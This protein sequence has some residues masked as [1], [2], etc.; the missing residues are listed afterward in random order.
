MVTDR[1][2]FAD[3]LEVVLGDF[4]LGGGAA[5]WENADLERFLEGL[6]TLAWARVNALEGQE[7]ASWRLFAE[8]IVAATGYE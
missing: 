2:T 3:F 4:R 8:M 1:D 6:A 7:Q 5:Q